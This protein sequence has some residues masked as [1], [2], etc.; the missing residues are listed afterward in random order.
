M[1]EGEVCVLCRVHGGGLCREDNTIESVQWFGGCESGGD[2]RLQPLLD[3]CGCD[4]IRTWLDQPGE[5]RGTSKERG[6][7]GWVGWDGGRG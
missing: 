7:S 5:N 1:C 3:F 2:C 6:N 4:E